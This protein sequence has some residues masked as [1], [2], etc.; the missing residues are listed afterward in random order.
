MSG[1]FSLQQTYAYVG[2][3]AS[4]V[5]MQLDLATYSLYIYKCI[6]SCCFLLKE[7]GAVSIQYRNREYV[8]I[9][10]V[11]GRRSERK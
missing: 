8:D 10:K 4:H 2:M 6:H 9:I 7:Q 3:N 5:V 11:Q 1:W